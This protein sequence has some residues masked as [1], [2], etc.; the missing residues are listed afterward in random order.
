MMRYVTDESARDYVSLSRELAYIESYITLQELRF[1]RTVGISSIVTGEAEG[2][3]IAPMLL[4]PFIENA[5]KHGINPEEESGIVVRINIAND[6]LYLNVR[7]R[8]VHVQRE[9]ERGL[10]LANT[11]SRLNLLYPGR[12]ELDSSAEDGVY[13]INLTLT[14]V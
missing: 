9:D 8:L 7:N 1:G 14:L 10:G 11:I 2:Y 6:T 3:Q 5:F 13:S 4:I 12:Y